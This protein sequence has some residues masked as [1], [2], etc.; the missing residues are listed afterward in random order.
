M[1]LLYETK[2][3]LLPLFVPLSELCGWLVCCF[4]SSKGVSIMF[5]T[6]LSHNHQ[7]KENMEGSTPL[8]R[9]LRD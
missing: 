7:M 5:L 6:P 8:R 4:L 2:S 3:L 1:V 9:I